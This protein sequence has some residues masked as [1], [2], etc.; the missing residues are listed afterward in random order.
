[1]SLEEKLFIN[2]AIFCEVADENNFVFKYVKKDKIKIGK[3]EW[4]G[5]LGELE[6]SC[7]C[8]RVAY[9]KPGCM[10]K[11]K[12]YHE[13][14]CSAIFSDQLNEGLAKQKSANARNGVVGLNNL[15]NT[16]F[17]NSSIQCIS[18][19]YELTKFFLDQKHIYCTKTAEQN[20]LSTGGKLA[21][22]YGK[23]LNEMWLQDSHSVNPQI[24]KR[25][26][27]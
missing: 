16:C 14:Y 22:A 27:G 7:K 24:F 15:G 9:C 6:V 23:I 4:C 11:D 17:M 5:Q 8:N 21:L 26:L 25:I 13:R 3:C 18:N 20:V 12:T 19:C 10:Q 1:M 2:Q